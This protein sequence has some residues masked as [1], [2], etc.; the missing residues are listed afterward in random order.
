MHVYVPHVCRCLQWPKEVIKSSETGVKYGF[1]YHMGV[2]KQ[3]R[4][5]KSREFSEIIKY[6]SNSEI[7]F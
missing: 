2:E 4:F 1:G 3:T 6:L 7:L 5:C